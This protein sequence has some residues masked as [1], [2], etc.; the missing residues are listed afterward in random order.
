MDTNH[1]HL[2]V[3]QNSA[4]ALPNEEPSQVSRLWGS[5]RFDFR[6]NDDYSAF[7]VVALSWWDEASYAR[8]Q[9]D[10]DHYEYLSASDEEE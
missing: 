3:I 9:G 2:R 7:F 6:W 1:L 5:D 8:Y 10:D 4:D